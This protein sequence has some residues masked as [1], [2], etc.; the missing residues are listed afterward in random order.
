[1]AAV[2]SGLEDR[3]YRQI[4]IFR[5]EMDEK[6]DGSLKAGSLPNLKCILAVAYLVLEI[7]ALR[8]YFSSRKRSILNNPLIQNTFGT[9][10]SNLKSIQFKTPL[11]ANIRLELNQSGSASVN[12]L[13]L[14]MVN[15]LIVA[16]FNKISLVSMIVVAIPVRRDSLAVEL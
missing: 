14:V 2:I 3:N 7:I 1:M 11:V 15:C 12:P 10:S 4:S 5:W 9:F 6:S 16:S 13:L 8:I